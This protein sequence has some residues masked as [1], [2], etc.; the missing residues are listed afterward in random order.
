MSIEKILRFSGFLDKVQPVLMIYLDG[1]RTWN[2]R[3]ITLDM[4]KEKKDEKVQI[5]PEVAKYW[6]EFIV[7]LEEKK[8]KL[9]LK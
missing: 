8:D 1:G 4:I 6:E 3:N 9:F 7:L 5:S 2:E